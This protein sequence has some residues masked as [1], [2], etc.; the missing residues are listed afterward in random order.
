MAQCLHC[1]SDNFRQQ[2]PGAITNSY[3]C[4]DCK[5]SFDK[6]S[7]TSKWGLISTAASIVVAVLFGIN[8]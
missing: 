6:L 4:M 7:P 1:G 5:K 2:E 3:Y 8:K